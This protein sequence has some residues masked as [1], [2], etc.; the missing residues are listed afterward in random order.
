MPKPRLLISHS[1]DGD[2]TNK[3]I[4]DKLAEALEKHFAILLDRKTLPVGHG[5]RNTLNVW[6][7]TC[8]A[9]IV[10]VTPQA[11]RSEFCLYEW[12]I[13]GFRRGLNPTFPIIVIYHGVDPDDFQNKPH[14]LGSLQGVALEYSSIAAAKKKVIAALKGVANVGDSPAERQ[15]QFVAAVLEDNVSDKRALRRAAAVVRSEIQS[16]SPTEDDY[17]MF[18]LQLTAASLPLAVKS[19]DELVPYFREKEKA[20][21]DLLHIVS[22]SWI[23]LRLS[24]TI[25][26]RALAP[27]PPR[28]AVALNAARA[29][30][31]S[32]CVLRASAKPPSNT[33]RV[34]DIPNRFENVDQLIEQIYV[35]L[36]PLF[37]QPADPPVRATLQKSL[38]RENRNGTPV[39]VA[40]QDA[41]VDDKLL[42]ELRKEFRTVMFF[43]LTANRVIRESEF[44]NV[45]LIIP[46]LPED[47]ETTFWNEYDDAKAFFQEKPNAFAD[48]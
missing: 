43:L 42:A 3:P 11:L 45:A 35:S 2:K 39:V 47:F 33:W 20:F 36:A 17:L 40:L 32:L 34:A 28:R 9:A 23:D 6:T 48:G 13:L 10:F 21:F 22:C 25:S 38:E 5:W 19:L 24:E 44:R 30:T 26:D 41:G 4:V 12:N 27:D 46:P 1:T 8:D 15:A 29:T 7:G 18:A 37:R 31:A 16:W 14:Q